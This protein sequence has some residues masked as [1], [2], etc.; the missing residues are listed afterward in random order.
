MKIIRSN[1]IE[2]V[3]A[4]H[5]DAHDPGALKKV[6]LSVADHIEGKVQMVNWA[7]IAPGRSFR[8]HYHEDMWEIFIILSGP[9]V[10]TVNETHVTLGKGDAFI[11][12]PKETHSMSNP[13]DNP[14]EYIVFGV[15]RGSSGKTVNT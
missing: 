5:E 6:L 12:E 13:G 15:V 3:P 11:I 7:T 8:S 1:E 14:L 9:A 10:I 2:Q 4:S